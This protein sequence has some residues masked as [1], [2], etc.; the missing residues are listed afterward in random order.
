MKIENAGPSIGPEEIAELEKK[1]GVRLPPSY[2]EFLLRF[3]GGVPRPDGIDVSG[4]PDMP[5]DVQVFFGIGRDV[6][7]SDLYW[8]FSLVKNM[9]IGLQFF[10]L[11][12]DSGGNF[13]C[14]AV[15]EGSAMEV[16]YVDICSSPPVF[17]LVAPSFEGF[18]DK[19]TDLW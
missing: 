12:C 19:I 2:R 15:D 9:R 4:P 10:P 14:F 11:A 7:S 5:T 3:N 1:V 18:I 6:N 16:F 8:N 17:Y 13:F